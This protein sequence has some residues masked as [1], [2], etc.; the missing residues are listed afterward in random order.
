MSPQSIGHI[1]IL[2]ILMFIIP[3][4]IT[5]KV[6]HTEFINTLPDKLRNT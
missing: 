6:I 3:Q 4:K 1:M 5:E 2:E